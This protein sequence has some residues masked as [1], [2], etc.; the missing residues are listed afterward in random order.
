M[1]GCEEDKKKR[2][3]QEG[4]EAREKTKDGRNE[5][6]DRRGERTKMIG[7]RVR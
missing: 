1:V 3:K 2:K 7:G 6:M 5:K 4:W